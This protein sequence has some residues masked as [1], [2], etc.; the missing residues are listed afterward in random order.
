M[1]TATVPVKPKILLGLSGSVASIKV[2]ELC[3]A[4]TQFAEV[5]V[6]ATKSALH[7]FDFS[8]LPNIQAFHRDE[9]EWN[10]KQ[11]GDPVLH[12]E[13]RKWADVLI[14]A[15]LSAN[16]LAKLSNGLCDNLLTCVARA[17]DFRNPLIVA[18]AMNTLMWEHPLTSKQ[19]DTLEGWG[20]TVIQPVTKTLM[21]NDTGRGAM[22]S[23]DDISQTEA[24][25]AAPI[26]VEDIMVRAG[27]KERPEA[28]I[29]NSVTQAQTHTLLY[30]HTTTTTHERTQMTTSSKIV[31]ITIRDLSGAQLVLDATPNQTLSSIRQLVS[32]TERFRDR[33]AYDLIYDGK[34]L[35]L[36]GTTATEKLVDGAVIHML[37]NTVTKPPSPGTSPFRGSPDSYKETGVA[38][39]DY[40]QTVFEHIANRWDIRGFRGGD[41]KVDEARLGEA[42][43]IQ[44]CVDTTVSIPVKKVNRILLDRCT[45]VKLSFNS[46]ISKLEIVNGVDVEVFVEGAAPTVQ[47]D[48]SR[49]ITLHFSSSSP[50]LT[51]MRF[52]HASCSN[53]TIDIADEHIQMQIPT[54]IL[55]DQMASRISLA[56]GRYV[57]KSLGTERMKKGG[58]LNL[59]LLDSSDGIAIPVPLR[60]LLWAAADM[61]VLLLCTLIVFTSSQLAAYRDL[62]AETG[63]TG[64]KNKSGWDGQDPCDFFGIT[65]DNDVP[66]RIE[67]QNNNPIGYIPYSLQQ[68]NLS[69]IDLSNNQLSG[70]LPD[71]FYNMSSLRTL[72]ISYNGFT[73]YPSSMFNSYITHLH[74]EYNQ[75]EGS[76]PTIT[77]SSLQVLTS[78]WN[79]FSGVMP[80]S[81]STLTEM[82]YL[83]I[84]SNHLIGSLQGIFDNM[85]SL[86]TLAIGA[87]GFNSTIPDQ[88]V[89]LPDLIFLNLEWNNAMVGSIPE[90]PLGS[91]LQSLR[92][93]HNIFAGSI[94]RSL[95]YLQDLYWLD[96]SANSLTGSI[97]D[98]LFNM[99]SLEV[100]YMNGNI[101]S[102]QLPEFISSYSLYD[103]V[104]NSNY[105]SGSIP[106]SWHNMYNAEEIDLSVNGLSGDIFGIF[107]NMTKLEYPFLKPT[108]NSQN[109]LTGDLPD[110]FPSSLLYFKAQYNQFT[111]SIPPALLTNPNMWYLD[112][113]KNNLNGLLP[114]DFS[115]MISLQYLHLSMNT[116]VGTIPESIGQLKNLRVLGLYQNHLTGTI[117]K[118]LANAT[119]L[120]SIMLYDNLLTGVI[121]AELGR[122]KSLYLF[123]IHFNSIS[124]T[125]PMTLCNTS[126]QTLSLSYN[127][128]I[129]PL[130]FISCMPSLISFDASFCQFSGMI[131]PSVN[132]LNSLNVLS[133]L[134]NDNLLTGSIP[135]FSP[136]AAV[137]SIKLQNNDLTGS[138]PAMLGTDLRWLDVSGNRLNG[139]IPLQL[140]SYVRLRLVI[141]KSLVNL[142]IFDVSYNRLTGRLLFDGLNYLNSIRTL[143]LA[144]NNL[145]GG[146]FTVT[147]AL[148][149]LQYFDVS[150]NSFHGVLPVNLNGPMITY[151]NFSHNQIAD[152]FPTK[153]SSLTQLEV[154]DISHNN[155]YGQLANGIGRFPK[156]KQILFDNNFIQGT[157]PNSLGHLTSL[158]T[159]SLSNNRLEADNLEF[160]SSM[161]QLKTLNLSGNLIRAR[162]P[163]SLAPFITSIDISG[164]QLYG[165]IPDSLFSMRNLES[166]QLQNN[167][168]QGTFRRLISDPKILDLSDNF[169]SG[170]V[171]FLSQLSSISHLSLHNNNFSGQLPAL[172]SRKNLIHVDISRNRLEGQLPDFTNLL[173]LVTLNASDNRFSG[174][175]PSFLGSTSLSELDLSSNNLS[176]ARTSDLPDDISCDISSNSLRCPISWELFAQCS[177][178]CST[179]GPNVPQ[180][181]HFHMEGS[182]DKFD[183]LHFISTLSSLSNVS[184]SRLSLSDVRSGSII[185]TVRVIPYEGVNEGSVNDTI[186]ILED[187]SSVDMSKSGY[188]LLDP[189]GSLPSSVQN[190]NDSVAPLLG[191]LLGGFACVGIILSVAFFFYRRRVHRRS[192]MR[193]LKLIDFTKLNTATVKKSLIDFDHLK[194]M[195]M[196]GS[197]AFGVVYKANWRETEVAIRSEL[198]TQKQM[199][200]FLHE[201]SIL[202]GLKSHPNIVMF[203]E[204]CGGGS[205]Y[206]HLRTNQST[207]QDKYRYISEISLGML[208]LHKEKIIHRDL[209]VRN[210][211]LSRHLEV[212]VSDFGLS[213]EQDDTNEASQTQNM[214]GPLKWMAPEAISDRQYSI[215]SD[216]FSFGVVI[217]EILQ[218]REPWIN[219]TAVEAAFHVIHRNERLTIPE[220]SPPLLS[221]MMQRCWQKDPT[222]RPNFEDICTDL[223]SIP[224]VI[225]PPD[226]TAE[227]DLDREGYDHAGGIQASPTEG[228]YVGT[229]TRDY[230]T[231][232][233]DANVS[234]E[235]ITLIEMDTWTTEGR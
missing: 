13:L 41:L 68:F 83:D 97:P 164:N 1:D 104:I 141:L 215:K 230:A 20:V 227:D 187:I 35:P 98:C 233:E 25:E 176:L 185:A 191:G 172:T 47:I 222:A 183:A 102:G 72:N 171:T 221:D 73:D 92:L 50:G 56:Q 42:V 22:A 182:V 157:L 198:V 224:H 194:D 62:Y 207:M 34:V 210:I 129:G 39:V 122:L 74:I 228:G 8:T 36:T 205:L 199:E 95:C 206:N 45:R 94:P 155:L 166:I 204:F 189:I 105:L 14:I 77:N 85:T 49:D 127:N 225:L 26:T 145:T 193:Q 51:D 126:M 173:S 170:D 64:W 69:Y 58:Y 219:L 226:E 124:G 167:M 144:C 78:Q 181:L 32:D 12:I 232:Y 21:C 162:I 23:V 135:R 203:I 120:G 87:N 116:L 52:V 136:R 154:I 125:V 101:L 44:D 137:Q 16:T 4:L 90:F 82:I 2:R 175:F 143:N 10:W 212:K 46:V 231:V 3:I 91:R 60:I 150:Q 142:E 201:V 128:L 118:S 37:P 86:Q 108:P 109:K 119:R 138:I 229:I 174:R 63:G 33:G 29:P 24:A 89:M 235:S 70:K 234:R 17:W 121:P 188:T 169:F 38:K 107:G 211:L 148:A 192:I 161:T 28:I 84:S 202:Q 11:R 209:A 152:V 31:Q 158:T 96:L 196:I 30:R 163:D 66:V 9:D 65:C 18:P 53:V 48:L 15:P 27:S 88:L 80:P 223:R 133:F 216:M 5:K 195:K 114:L 153:Y 134:L 7:F 146:I 197:G 130:D 67:L 111:G 81:W 59:S 43:L 159:L 54:S 220:D 115:H 177:A 217:W 19:L 165:P 184:S 213:R 178:I 106:K 156:L 186:G 6:I 131:P 76:L 190:A 100:V 55:Q 180:L 57:L 93:T 103:L 99:S 208:H 160:L 113:Q 110:A 112:I 71:V 61:R 132:R 117:P 140:A 123:V 149:R 218:V 168:L 75:L 147:D 79:G 179:Q 40:N 151:L 200:E 139:S 214:V